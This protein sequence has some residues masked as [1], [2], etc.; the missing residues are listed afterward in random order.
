MIR[1]QP[2]FASILRVTRDD[3]KTMHVIRFNILGIIYLMG[4]FY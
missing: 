4:F 1:L 2:L 3:V